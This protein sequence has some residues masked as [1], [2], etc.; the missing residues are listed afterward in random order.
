MFVW[1]PYLNSTKLHEELVLYRRGFNSA[2]NGQVNRSQS[3]SIVVIGGGLWDV[4][5]TDVAPLKHFT[6]SVDEIVSSMQPRLQYKAG[7]APQSS[8]NALADQDLLLLTP[9]QM[10]LYNALSS[11]RAKDITPTKVDLMNDYLHQVSGTGEAT[12]LWSYSLMTWQQQAAYE[13]G[14]LHVLDTVASRQADILLNLRCNAKLDTLGHYPFDRTCCSRY[15]R[16][17]QVQC[18]L[19]SYGLWIFPLLSIAVGKGKLLKTIELTG[20]DSMTKIVNVCRC[21]LP[22]RYFMLF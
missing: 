13:E 2:E 16:P 18:T 14:G 15:T 1:D 19:L 17:N 5:Y 6:V 22:A 3:A 7:P 21:F 8:V 4:R 11:V 20:T 12:V 9:V 10:P